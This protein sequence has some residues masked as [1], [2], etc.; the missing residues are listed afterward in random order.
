M[1]ERRQ[2][3]RRRYGQTLAENC[4]HGNIV[5]LYDTDVGRGGALQLFTCRR[6]RSAGFVD[7]PAA[8]LFPVFTTFS[9]DELPPINI[10]Q[11]AN[12]ILLADGQRITYGSRLRPHCFYRDTAEHDRIASRAQPSRILWF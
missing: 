1:A 11:T 3:D 10:S 5:S 12:A 4:C 2:E 6:S 8:S 9:A 7:T